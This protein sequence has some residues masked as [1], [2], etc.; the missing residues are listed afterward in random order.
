MEGQSNQDRT[1]NGADWSIMANAWFTND[2]V[3]DIN[4]DG[5]VNSIDFSLLNANWGRTI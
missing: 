1:V 5:I 2:A 4:A 3:A